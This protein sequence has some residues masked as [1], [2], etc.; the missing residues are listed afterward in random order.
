TDEPGL[1]VLGMRFQRR[2]NSNFIDGVGND[3]AELSRHLAES[4]HDR[5][6]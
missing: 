2:K 4:L 6:A 1:Y 5:A 3:A